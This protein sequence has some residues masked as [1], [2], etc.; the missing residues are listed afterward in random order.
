MRLIVLAAALMSASTLAGC[1]TAA[2]ASA[3]GLKR[4][5]G[6]DLIGARGLTSADKRKIGR[7]VASLCAAS[8][9]SKDQCRQHDKAIQAP[10]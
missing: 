5:V 3:D 1:S 8:I 7:T 6:T 4:V 10:L 9:W 2:P